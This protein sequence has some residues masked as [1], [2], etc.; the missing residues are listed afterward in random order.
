MTEVLRPAMF[1]IYSFVS[2]SIC[3]WRG[4]IL[5]EILECELKDT[6]G[7]NNSVL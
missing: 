1:G 3:L 6:S 2:V 4:D 5:K 7:F